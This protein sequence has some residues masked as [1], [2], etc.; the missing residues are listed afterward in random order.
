MEVFIVSLKPAGIHVRVWYKVDFDYFT[1]VV[2][3][4]RRR[5]RNLFF[6]VLGYEILIHGLKVLEI[7]IRLISLDDTKSAKVGQY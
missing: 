6:I 1:V 2:I 3:S 7:C 4:G 5:C